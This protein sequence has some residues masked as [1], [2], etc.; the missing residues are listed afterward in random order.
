MNTVTHALL[1][2][3]AVR[4]ATGH[5]FCGWQFVG[6]GVCGALP[7][8]INPHLSLAARMSSW[9]H[10]LPAWGVVSFLCL[11]AVPLSGNRWGW[12][13]ALCGAMAY[14]LHLF[15]DAIAGGINWLSPFGEAYWG[16]YWFPV[17]WWTPTDAL[18]LLTAYF[19]FRAIPK[20][21]EARTQRGVETARPESSS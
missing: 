21:R 17:V 10:G 5:R 8:L 15:C 18:L 12:G 9:S 1:P 20:W 16:E 11:A 2:V 19:V 3:L 14:L 7:D 13:L 4:V 6:L